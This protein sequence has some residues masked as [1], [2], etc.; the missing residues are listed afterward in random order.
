MHKRMDREI[1]L[2]DSPRDS[3]RECLRLRTSARVGSRRL[4]DAGRSPF[5][6]RILEEMNNYDLYD[7]LVELGERADVL[8]ETK[9]RMFAA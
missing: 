2:G 4:P 9:E 1:L 6:V 5:H 8:H 3:L 7:V